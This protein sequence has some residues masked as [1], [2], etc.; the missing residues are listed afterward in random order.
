[1]FFTIKPY[2]HLNLVL[3][4]NWILWN[5]TIFI[6][7]DLALNNLQG[8]I[9]RKTQTTKPLR[10]KDV[11]NILSKYFLGKTTDFFKDRIKNLP[12]CCAAVVEN[13]SDYIFW[14]NLNRFDLRLFLYLLC[15][16]CN[17]FPNT[18]E[19]VKSFGIF[20]YNPY[21]PIPLSGRIWHKVNF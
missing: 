5:R 19:E 15:Y 4:L 13:E 17:Y 9:C 12:S 2:L 16:K 6:K 20:L 21:L 11:E 10:N 1:M 3:M 14:L 7:V 18:Q 8:L